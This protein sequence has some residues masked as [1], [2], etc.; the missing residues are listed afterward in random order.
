MKEISVLDIG[1]VFI[2]NAADKDGATGLTVIVCPDGAPCGVDIRG[3]GPASRETHLLNPLSAAEKIH[4]V[5]L[6]GGSAFGL[7]CAGG[8]MEYLENQGIGF[9]TGITKVPLVC[10]SCIYDLICGDYRCRPDKKMGFEATCNAF[11]RKPLLWGN[12]GVGTG[13][14]IG[15]LS[16][17]AFA[18]KSGLGSFALQIGELKVGA[19]VAVN[20]LGDIYENGKILAGML[21]SDGTFADSAKVIYQNLEPKENLFTGNTTIGAVITNAEFTKAE[22]NKIAAMASN[23]YAR[24]IRPVNTTADGDSLYAMSVGTVKADINVVGT[25]AADVM[26]KAIVN[27]VKEAASDYGFKA[28]RDL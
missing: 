2:G 4:A 20:A 28:V 10:T 7:D 13:A 6:S 22:M 17:P 26:E 16:G 9:D 18:L 3:G 27:A 25:L 24:A 1:N 12:E 5:V 19:V 11:E 21:S 8:V 14:T 15:K 23:A